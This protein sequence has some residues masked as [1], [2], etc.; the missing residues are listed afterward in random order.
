[1]KTV[2]EL[3]ILKTKE[4]LFNNSDEK[5]YELSLKAFSEMI[6]KGITKPRGYCLSS[7][8]DCTDVS[9]INRDLSNKN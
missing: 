5:Q 4:N 3:E 6:K 8:A 7:I 2:K 1:M 9:F